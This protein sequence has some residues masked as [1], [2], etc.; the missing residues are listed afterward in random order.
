LG[1][2][3]SST[4]AIAVA[5]NIAVTDGAVVAINVVAIFKVFIVKCEAVVRAD[6]AVVVPNIIAVEIAVAVGAAIAVEVV[7]TDAVIY[8]F[9]VEGSIVGADA[10]VVVAVDIDITVCASV[11]TSVAIA[12]VVIK[13]PF[14]NDSIVGADAPVVAPNIV[15]VDITITVCTSVATSVAIA[16]VVIEVPVVEES[17]VGAD[18]PVVAPNAVA[19]GGSEHIV[20]EQIVAGAVDAAI[21]NGALAGE[22]GAAASAGAAATAAVVWDAVAFAGGGADIVVDGEAGGVVDKAVLAGSVVVGNVVE[23]PVQDPDSSFFPMKQ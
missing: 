2:R 15:A 20:V 12:D 5:V 6:V 3:G 1:R 22:K 14:A 9:L 7:A 21:S 4:N 19:H 18:A 11:A 13:V 17:I 8:V 16:D 23:Y 10:P